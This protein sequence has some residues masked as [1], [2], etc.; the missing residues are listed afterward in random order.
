MKEKIEKTFKNQHEKNCIQL[1][2]NLSEEKET[3]SI[4]SNLPKQISFPFISNPFHLEPRHFHVI[5][6]LLKNL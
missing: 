1:V 2:M 4:F 6:L 3:I 5:S